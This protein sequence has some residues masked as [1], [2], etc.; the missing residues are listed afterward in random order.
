MEFII[1][2]GWLLCGLLGRIVGSQKGAGTAGTVL[3][4]LFGPIGV[5]V[6]GFI[7][8]RPCCPTCGTRL[9]QRPVLCPACKTR[10]KWNGKECEFFP[11]K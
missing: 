1:L 10:F 3:G 8:A 4:L 11:P 2:G 7:D 5:I 6:A 9:N